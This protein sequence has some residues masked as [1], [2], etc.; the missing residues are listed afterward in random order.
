VSLGGGMTGAKFLETAAGKGAAGSFAS[1]VAIY[2]ALN[3]IPNFVFNQAE[4]AARKEIQ[5]K[6]QLLMANDVNKGDW[7]AHDRVTNTLSKYKLKTPQEIQLIALA[8]DTLRNPG[9]NAK[10]LYA[11]YSLF[12]ASLP[13]FN[14]LPTWFARSEEVKQVAEKQLEQQKAVRL[15]LQ[16]RLKMLWGESDAKK[17]DYDGGAKPASFF[18]QVALPSDE[19]AAMLSTKIEFSATETRTVKGDR[20]KGEQLYRT[21]EVGL[22]A[23]HPRAKEAKAFKFI[24]EK[25]ASLSDDALRSSLKKDYGISDV[26]AFLKKVSVKRL[27]EQISGLVSKAT[28]ETEELA[29]WAQNNDL[30][31][32]FNSD[33][34]IKSNMGR[35][36]LA[37]TLGGSTN[38]YEIA[39]LEDRKV[40]RAG[41]LLT[42]AK[43][44]AG[45]GSRLGTDY[46]LGFVKRDGSLD[47]SN[48]YILAYINTMK[49]YFAS[50]TQT[51]GAQN[52]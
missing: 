35:E 38:K 42:G 12:I 20:M 10:A 33:G 46:A 47:E 24:N 43:A 52:G 19:L 39:V 15:E 34:T 23:D 7:T 17:L 29:G 14:N 2:A 4:M 3:E 18:S 31:M 22:P 44:D 21:I 41:A 26:D 49:N 25:G 13:I 37:F 30:R 50:L 16:A 28:R 9:K 1:A 48:K 6:G 36:L 51:G 32:I 8:A 11:G 5:D 40:K 45:E 27:Q